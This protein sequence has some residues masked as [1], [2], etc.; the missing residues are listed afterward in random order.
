[1]ASRMCVA[2]RASR[3]T[4]GPLPRSFVRMSG[5]IRSNSTQNIS[6]VSAEKGSLTYTSY[7]GNSWAAKFQNTGAT[8]LVDPWLVGNLTFGGLDFIYSGSKRVTTPEKVDLDEIA[9]TTDFVLLTMSIDDHAH[10]PTLQA[11]VQKNANIPI[12]ASPSAAKVSRDIGFKRVYEL[13]HGEKVTLLDGKITVQA[14][15]GALVGPPWSKRENG[16]VISEKDGISVYY[17]PHA[18]Y[19]VDSVRKIGACDIVVSPPCTQSL[20]GYDLVKGT[21]ENIP[22]LQ[23]LKPKAVIALMNAEFNG[24]GPLAALISET[25]GPSLLESQIKDSPSVDAHV[26]VPKAGEP[27]TVDV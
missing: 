18:D 3:T 5:R 23:L 24:T 22:L 16:F 19:N 15:E 6:R 7:E 10:K 20:L 21:S 25:G 17:E 26:F 8:M 11:L 14:T 4:G 13:D 1:M 2:S 27:L 12:V 9:K